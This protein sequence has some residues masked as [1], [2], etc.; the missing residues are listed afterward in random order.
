GPAVNLHFGHLKKII[1]H[2]IIKGQDA[3]PLAAKRAAWVGGLRNFNDHARSGAG[4]AAVGKQVCAPDLVTNLA[5]VI[6]VY[7]DP[8]V[9]EPLRATAVLSRVDV[10]FLDINLR[11]QVD[12][13]GEPRRDGRVA[14]DHI[15]SVAIDDHGDVPAPWSPEWSIGKGRLALG[16]IV[17]E[18]DRGF[19]ADG[20]GGAWIGYDATVFRPHIGIRQRGGRIVC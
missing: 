14:V 18:A 8:D 6:L 10:D 20:I 12:G 13:I 7:G 3:N 5:I 1:E 16:I 19:A 4:V 15:G 17:I 11:A 9:G 2:G